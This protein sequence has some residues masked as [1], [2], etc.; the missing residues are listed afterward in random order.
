MLEFQESRL[1]LLKTRTFRALRNRNVRL[2]MIG[3]SISM[4][5]TYMQLVAEGWLIY[6]LTDSAFGLGLVGFLAMIPLAPFGLIAG[7][8]ADRAFKKKLLA[9][10]Q[11]GQMVPPLALAALVWTGRV[12]VWH[13]LACSVIMGAMATI[14]FTSRHAMV[15]S[16]VER[17][18]VEGTFSLAV[19]VYNIARILGP[20]MAGFVIAYVGLAAAF[21]LNGLSFAA[22][23]LALALMHVKEPPAPARRQS[24]HANLMEV[25]RHVFQ[26]RTILGLLVLMIGASFFILPYQT[27][28]PV[29]ARDIFQAGPQ[30]LGF[31]TSAAGVG[32]VLGAIYVTSQPHV[33]PG[34]RLRLPIILTI[35]IAPFAAAFAFSQNM[36]LAALFLVIVSAG[37]IALKTLGTTYVQLETDDRLR[38]R[39]ASILQ[40]TE[41]ATPRVGGLSAGFLASY[42][43]AAISMAIGALACLAF[44]L[45]ALA[46]FRPGSVHAAETS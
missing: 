38:G 17:E 20:V 13:I 2:F 44:G 15:S 41:A 16:V 5:G 23:L 9:F 18:D 26:Q 30:G 29:F 42:F 39:M 4:A 25:A 19:A 37:I 28:L 33:S 10:A 31:L 35:V 43:G 40:L 32:A 45:A 7:A 12:Q 21:A 22:V 11:V 14:D 1:T 8:L 34:R 3:M 27:L 46:I 24:L 36:V 6:Q